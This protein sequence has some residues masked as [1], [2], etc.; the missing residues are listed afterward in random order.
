MDSL[1]YWKDREAKNLERNKK[2]EKQ[3]EKKIKEIYETMLDSINKEIESFYAKY[4][5]KEGITMA[6]AK[7]RV[8]NADIEAYERKAKEY[9][10]NKVFTEK[11]NEEMR[12]YNATMKINRLELLK[13][14]I[15]AEMCKG[16]SEYERFMEEILD[17]RTEEEIERQAGILKTGISN[18]SKKIS[19][20]VN[21]S[22]Y[23][24]T[25]SDR[26][27]L[28]QAQLKAE[29][30][31]LL[32]NG[33]IQGKNPRELAREIRKVFDVSIYNSER[34]MRTELCRVQT[35]VQKESFQ[36][37]EYEEYTFIAEPTACEV[38]KALNGKHFKVVKMQ[39]GLNA[40]P[41]HPNC[42]CSTAAY[43]N[44]EEFDKWLSKFEKRG[45]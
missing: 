4:A 36:K 33:I 29:L 34:L 14:Q 10:K 37:N 32:A 1:Q 45:K 43:M 41:I 7:K 2:Q 6:E 15:G 31:K 27:W 38:C 26:I 8:A 20:V 12:L 3:Y 23:N 11:A 30:E 18:T 21:S 17:G 40:P 19:S 39:Y 44:R 35:E 25:F 24:A 9:V 28:N 22:F 42:R 16:Y 13:A 5:K